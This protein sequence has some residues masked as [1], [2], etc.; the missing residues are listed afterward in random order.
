MAELTS[1]HKHIKITTI[2][3]T[4]NEKDL[5]LAGRSFTTE[6]IMKMVGGV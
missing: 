4:I 3:R 2:H 1:S 5:N 6:Y